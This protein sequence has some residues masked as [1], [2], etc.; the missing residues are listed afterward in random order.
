MNKYLTELG[1]KDKNIG[2][3]F[4]NRT[5]RILFRRENIGRDSEF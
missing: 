3:T 4:E 5:V 1:K 2:L